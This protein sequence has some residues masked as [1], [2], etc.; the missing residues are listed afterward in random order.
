MNWGLE[1]MQGQVDCQHPMSVMKLNWL[2]YISV[3]FY[4]TL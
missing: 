3:T 4:V 2:L 1:A